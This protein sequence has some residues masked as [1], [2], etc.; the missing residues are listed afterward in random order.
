MKKEFILISLLFLLVSVF[1]ISGIIFNDKLIGRSMDFSV[2]PVSY[3]VKNNFLISFYQWWGTINGG[4]RNTFT[5]TVIPVNSI[6]YL[7]LLFGANV[8]FIGRY[9][10]IL[11]L[12]L[13]MLFF[14]ILSRRLLEDSKIEEKYKI[15]LSVIGSL[16]FVLS[17]YFFLELIFGS[18]AMYFTFALIPLLIYSAISYLKYRK[19]TYFILSLFSLIVISSM[20]QH[21]IM[22][23]ILL[24]MLALIYKDF[25]F[26][27]KL[28][29]LHF[30]LSLYW[31]L[32]LLHS[33]SQV[34]AIEMVASN[35]SISL[36]E[37]SPSFFDALISK[38]YFSH[39]N[40]YNLALNSGYLSLLWVFNAF[41]LLI[42]SLLILLKN[43]F[44]KD[45]VQRKIILGFSALFMISLLFIKGGHDP[46]GFLVMYL[47]NNFSIFSLYR[48]IQHYIGF[49][50]ISI[51]ILFLFSGVFLINKNKKFVYLLLAVVL[52]N[53]MPWWRT[54]DLGTKNITASNLPPSYFNQF[55]LTK[56]NEKMYALNKLPLDFAIMHVPLGYSINF[57]AVDKNEFN[58][59]T[60]SGLKIKSQGGDNGLFYGDKR[61]FAT[62]GQP[63]SLS[64]VLDNLEKDMY[65]DKDFFGENKNLLALLGIRYFVIRDDAATEFSKNKPLFTNLENMKSSVEKSNIF[66]S[67]ERED[68]ITIAKMKD[69][70]PHIY[71]PQDIVLSAST[72][73]YLPD[74]VSESNYQIRSAVYFDIQNKNKLNGLALLNAESAKK[75]KLPNIEFK[76]ID[77]T[78][79]RIKAHGA[80]GVF[81][82]IFNESFNEEWKVYLNQNVKIK[83]QKD[84]LKFK[85]EEYKILDGNEKDQANKEELNDYINNGWVSD[86]G[87]EKNQINF[88]SKNFQG[89][90][91]NDNLPKGRI[92]ETW[93]KKPLP[94]ED[95]LT[96]N[97]YANSWV[98]NADK[99]CSESFCIKNPDDTYD[100]EL[101]VEFKPQQLFYVGLGMSGLA[102]LVYL[103]YNLRKQKIFN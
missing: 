35:F 67:L 83:N 54:L 87:E 84:N 68:F 4:V 32:P 49:Y 40:L 39:R 92:W 97:G 63:H 69:F 47:Y 48:S 22:A 76:K 3:L 2:P 31:I 94:E 21:F 70:L 85:N 7:P 95:H 64:N 58:F 23:Y 81:P 29:L 66:S 75:S 103:S 37:N 56:G 16:F 41:L 71:I 5:A 11:T 86:L 88:I 38:E 46:F 89:T 13:V 19:K 101:V 44:I 17:N 99:I 102:L 20:L 93:F 28:G 59:I 27:I 53:A 42:A 9:Q 24:F 73:E 91:Q 14:Y 57:L 55:Y 74:I 79:Y 8:W 78:K 82:L 61:F 60:R 96:V 33:L 12:F 72:V 80:T 18:N 100:F 98:I 90:I 25:K 34:A 36:I 51:S 45:S 43:S 15:I 52:V 6:L 77:P 50:T 1:V 10:I 30:C 65:L 62:D 26:L